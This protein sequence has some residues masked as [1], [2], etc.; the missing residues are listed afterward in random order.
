[1]VFVIALA[2]E[3]ML[4]G[5]LRRWLAG[6]PGRT[7]GRPLAA[8]L[9]AC[10][11]G[12]QGLH[13]WADAVGYSPVTRFTGMLPLYYPLHGKRTL[14]KLGWLDEERVRQARLLRQG[15]AEASGDLRYPLAPLQCAAPTGATPNVLWILID[16]LR[17]DAIDPVSSPA[18]AAFRD[19]GQYFANH[20]S[21]GNSSRMGL[22]SMFYGLPSTYWQS[23]YDVQRPPVLLEEFRRQ[24]YVLMTSSAVGYGSPTL[25]DR[26]VFA[27]VPG[28]KPESDEPGVLKNQQ[29]TADWLRWLDGRESQESRPGPFFAFLYYDPPF[30]GDDAPGLGPD[31]R[32]RANGKARERW[33]RYRNGVHMV[34]GEV[35]RV[36]AALESAGLQ[37]DTLV[38]ITS[39]HGYEFDDLGLG[40]YGHASNFGR[41]QLRATLLMHWPGKPARVYEHRTAHQDLPA[42]LLQG[43][44]G[45]TN[46]PADYSLGRNL[47]DGVSWDW[48]IAGSYH[49]HAIVEPGRIMVTQPGGFAEVLGPDYRPPAD[50]RLDAGLIEQ[51]LADMR[52]FYR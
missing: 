31:D 52:R 29:V 38:M 37:E 34:D 20:W 17:P 12:S 48:I 50:A 44:F 9:L 41:Y 24:G 45:C 18:L 25:I 10:W 3:A 23:F 28:L 19:T 49:D 39:D 15:S 4:A 13:V 26:T 51:S 42:T 11:L 7:G 8:A 2:F 5:T 33:L 27:G 14:A 43:L 36:L 30:T 22:F 40:Y 35:A 47:F 16:A 21:G 1:V 46:P 6:R 32:Y